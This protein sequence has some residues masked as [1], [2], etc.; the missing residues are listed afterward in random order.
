MRRIWWENGYQYAIIQA[1][2]EEVSAHVASMAI[3]D[4]KPVFITGLGSN[5]AIEYVSQIGQTKL[6][7]RLSIWRGL[8][9]DYMLVFIQ[10]SKLRVLNI[11]GF[12]LVD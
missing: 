10:I 7:C 3:K 1:V 4:Q 9:I 12:S 6:V 11:A 5:I 8:E 2:F